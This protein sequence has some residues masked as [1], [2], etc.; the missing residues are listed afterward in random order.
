MFENGCNFQRGLSKWKQIYFFE[1][2]LLFTIEFLNKNDIM[3]SSNRS[4]NNNSRFLWWLVRIYTRKQ[5]K[6]IDI[7]FI[8]HL[9]QG[10]K[11]QSYN[12]PSDSFSSL[13]FL[14][15]TPLENAG[16]AMPSKVDST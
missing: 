6:V 13:F 12:L 7:I 9:T 3:H 5:N 1:S 14:K 11:E 10:H 8:H 4:I 15:T 2:F 16:F